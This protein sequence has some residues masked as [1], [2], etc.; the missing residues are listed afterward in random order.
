MELLYNDGKAFCAGKD[1]ADSKPVRGY[2]MP[3]IH[4]FFWATGL[5]YK[6][7]KHTVID[8]DFVRG[9]DRL[10]AAF[11]VLSEFAVSLC[12]PLPCSLLLSTSR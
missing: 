6:R 11:K 12:C 8:V 5:T 3:C 9:E 4:A 1:F 2:R 7:L 10:G